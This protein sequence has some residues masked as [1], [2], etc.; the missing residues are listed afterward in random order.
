MD[1]FSWKSILE[2]IAKLQ[3]LDISV[4]SVILKEI[5]SESHY[6]TY[7]ERCQKEL[8]LAKSTKMKN[9]WVSFLNFII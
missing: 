4:N 8:L 1:E 5:N 6:E 9:S 3:A 2:H 7:F